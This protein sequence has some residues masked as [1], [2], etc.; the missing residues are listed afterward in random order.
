MRS[1]QDKIYV[2]GRLQL[3]QI[4]VRCGTGNGIHDGHACAWLRMRRHEQ[5]RIA[6][7][8]IHRPREGRD[9]RSVRAVASES[10]RLELRRGRPNREGT[11]RGLTHR[12]RSGVVGCDGGRA[13]NEAIGTARGIWC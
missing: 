5:H 13:R 10:K 8:H 9:R 6:S 7:H 1:W 3:E 11:R 4:A 12:D 2:D